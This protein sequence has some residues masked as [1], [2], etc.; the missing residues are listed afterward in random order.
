MR[1]MRL[2]VLFFTSSLGVGGA[3]MHLLRLV[4]HLD[5]SRFRVSVAVAR[6]GG[7]Y[8]GD[9]AP[10]APLYVLHAGSGRSSTRGMLGAL[11]PLRTLLRSLRPDVLCAVL[12][13]AG[14]IGLL[15]ARPF[16]GVMATVVCVQNS[17]DATYRNRLH[18]VR[19]A[20]RAG[21][22]AL[23]PRADAVVAP[24]RG[25][26]GELARMIPALAGSI[27]VIH[28]AGWDSLAQLRAAEPLDAPGR[29]A[30]P[31]V[32]AC[33]RL[34]E[35]KGFGVLL[36]A[37]ARVRTKLPAQLWIVGEGPRRRDLERT[38]AGLGLES[39]VRFCGHQRNPYRYMAAADLFVLSS[40][41]EGFGNVVAEAMACGTPVVSTDCPH[42]PGEI[43]RD[44]V[45]GL[46]V[47]P[48]DPAA[49]AGAMLRVLGDPALGARLARNGLARSRD[50][51]AERVAVEYGDLFLRLAGVR[52]AGARAAGGGMDVAA[53]GA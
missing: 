8:Q 51:H 23:F 47:P 48:G 5:R 28:N 19:A 27:P 6:G 14:I 32:V 53:T 24:S 10:D 3:E 38:A 20:V 11:A 52:A 1:G 16:R 36:E 9:L 15:A 39:C 34:A 25:V 50:F 40:L 45:S 41:W 7:S 4:N 44:G 13:H 37:M 26:A 35:Q 31:L 29:P 30:G 46:L 21:M 42:G 17:P 12:E 18:P 43:V 49:L 33:G 2:H 22:Y